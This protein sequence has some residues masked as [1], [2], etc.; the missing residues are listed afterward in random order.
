MR[1]LS[2]LLVLLLLTAMQVLAQ[3]TIT[4]KVTSAEDGGGIPG[5]TVLVKGTSNGVLTDLDGKYSISVPKTATALQFSFIG[6]QKQEI[7]LTAS[8]SLDVVM[9]SEA[10]KIEGVVVTALGISRDKKSL[11]Y[12]VQD[13]KGEDL[14]KAREANVINSLTG[15]VAGVQITNS[16][17]AVGASSR[18]VLRGVTSLSGDNQPLFVVDG[19]PID[20]RNFGA[21]AT[22][23]VNRGSGAGD[24]NPD[25]I[26]SVSVLKGP[27]AAALYGSRASNGVIIIT[28]KKGKMGKDKGVG[29]AYSNTSTFET[30]LRLPDY[31]NALWPGLRRP[32]QLF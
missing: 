11:G 14:A 13:V 29:I 5:V 17:G 2:F 30:P 18:I 4:G 1:K 25:D 23:G 20:N 15:K 27:N 3:R 16:S 31:Q 22:D 12:S 32:V 7:V 21:T 28:T 19:V 8:N 9:Q 6:M 24:I 26:E 10:T